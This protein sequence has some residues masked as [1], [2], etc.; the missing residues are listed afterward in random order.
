MSLKVLLLASLGFATKT[1]TRKCKLKNSEFGTAN[2]VGKKSVC[3]VYFS[4]KWPTAEIDV[5][6]LAALTAP[7]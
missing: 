5:G 4:Q 7:G 1:R 6:W 2:F 3:S